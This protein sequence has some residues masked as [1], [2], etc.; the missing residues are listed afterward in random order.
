MKNYLKFTLLLFALLLI[1]CQAEENIIA[2][3]PN[4]SKYSIS[5][6]QQNELFKDEKIA[7][8]LNKF[9]LNTS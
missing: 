8:I 7:K 5:K 6:Q 9:S 4:K 3:Q 2:N 1:N